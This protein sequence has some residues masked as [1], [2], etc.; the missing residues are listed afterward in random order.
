M[1]PVFT[2]APLLPALLTCAA[3]WAIAVWALNQRDPLTRV[4]QALTRPGESGAAEE[5][6][7]AIPVKQSHAIHSGQDGARRTRGVQGVVN[8][9]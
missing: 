1:I 6:P 8:I 3:A 4:V 2:S 5:G 9:P 7:G